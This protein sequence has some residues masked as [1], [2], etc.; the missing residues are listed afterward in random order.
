M[1]KAQDRIFSNLY[2]EKP[3]N[4]KTAQSRG[5]WD[6]TK[7]FIQKGRDWITQEIQASGLRG[8]GGAGFSTGKNGHLCQKTL[9]S[10]IT[11]W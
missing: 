10:R 9:K 4:L 2:G 5:D 3:W 8:R 1:L 11:Y 6:N 7:K